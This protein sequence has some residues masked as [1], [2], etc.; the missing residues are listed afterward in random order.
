MAKV[1]RDGG[2]VIYGRDSGLESVAGLAV[3]AGDAVV[4]S[5]VPR[6]R[7]L[8]GDQF[9]E[10]WAGLNGAG[11]GAVHAVSADEVWVNAQDTWFQLRDGAWNELGAGSGWCA[12]VLATDGALW[13]TSATDETGGGQLARI[14]TDGYQVIGDRA[15]AC[16]YGASQSP[17]P[18]GSVWVLQDDDVVR[19]WPDGRHENVGRP[20][21]VDPPIGD[22]G[23]GSAFEDRVCLHG[24]DPVGGVWV[25]EVSYVD[26]EECT[27]GTW[28]RWDGQ[29][30]SPADS[31]DPFFAQ[32]HVV[33]GDGIGWLLRYSD[34]QTRD[35]PVLPR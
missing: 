27:A 20:V 21:G 29:R 19:Y 15:P 6:V 11:I 12:P 35:R 22:R 25:S 10:I 1:A 23:Y 16:G 13:T 2:T 34:G 33:A 3:G 18:D 32:E 31:P 9:Q 30:W 4:I 28:H 26:D 7:R 17:G 14:S 24:V 8:D 5:D